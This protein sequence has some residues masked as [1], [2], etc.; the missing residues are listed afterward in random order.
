M[1]STLT[2]KSTVKYCYWAKALSIILFVATAAGCAPR[3]ALILRPPMP[4]LKSLP[5]IK[6]LPVIIPDIKS[7]PVL[8]PES[9]VVTS[10]PVEVNP[11]PAPR[12]PVSRAH[13]PPGH[14]PPPGKCRIWYPDRP[15]GHQP[16]PGNCKRL[17][18]H[19]PPGATLIRG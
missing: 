9:V 15:P 17:R 14:R 7:I 10:P 8:L 4:I 5:I 1:K 6:S 3:D 2:V 11:E 12:K 19:V 16:P 18:R 13:I